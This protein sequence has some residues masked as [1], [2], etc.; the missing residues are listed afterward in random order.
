M[1]HFRRDA[2][3]SYSGKKFDISWED[4]LNLFSLSIQKRMER[5]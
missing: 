4:I 3:T 5:K 2:F 1:W